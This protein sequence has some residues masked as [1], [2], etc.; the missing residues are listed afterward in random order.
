M[1][2]LVTGG[3]GFIGSHIAEAL[4][5]RGDAVR[6]LDNLTTGTLENIAV[7]ADK[8][9]FQKGD[10]R[11]SRDLE[12]A[13]KGIEVVFHQ[14]ALRSVPRSVDDPLG[15]NESNVTGTLNVLYQSRKAG[16]EARR[17]CFVLL[18]LWG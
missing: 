18:R 5:K 15:S 6:I 7:F 3:A 12:H 17:V 4:V 16:R 11:N 1:K 8:I 9:E 13:L 10:F 2:C 14:G